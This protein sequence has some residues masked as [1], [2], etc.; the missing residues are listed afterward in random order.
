MD[1]ETLKSLHSTMISAKK[2]FFTGLDE[3]EKEHGKAIVGSIIKSTCSNY[4]NR[5]FKVFDVCPAI[6][7]FTDELKIV[8]YY[9]AKLLDGKGNEI[10]G[11]VAKFDHSD[12]D[13]INR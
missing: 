5:K 3:Y 4:R 13:V 11:S 10:H 1:I 6:S 8:T 9:R 2:Y 12:F 7:G